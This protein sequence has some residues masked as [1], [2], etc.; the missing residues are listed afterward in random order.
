MTKQGMKENVVKAQ[1][2]NKKTIQY[3]VSMTMR[4]IVNKT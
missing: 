2:L 3:L 4:T 1:V